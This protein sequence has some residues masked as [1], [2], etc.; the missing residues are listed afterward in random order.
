MVQENMRN[1]GHTEQE[2]QWQVEYALAQKHIDQNKEMVGEITEYYVEPKSK[3]RVYEMCKNVY[4]A[5][6]VLALNNS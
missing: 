4:N 5:I 3:W 6:E 2:V 1:Q